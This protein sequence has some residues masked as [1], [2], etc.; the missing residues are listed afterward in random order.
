M[1]KLAENFEGGK[2]FNEPTSNSTNT[3]HREK[4]TLSF[5]LLYTLVESE[6]DIYFLQLISF[7]SKSTLLNK[8]LKDENINFAQSCVYV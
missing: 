6:R 5:L 4:K 2:Q 7:L 1:S 3:C 8:V